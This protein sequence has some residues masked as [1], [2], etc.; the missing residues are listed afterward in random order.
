MSSFN[1][2]EKASKFKR[3]DGSFFLQDRLSNKDIPKRLLDIVAS[4]LGLLLL[5]P[6]FGLIAIA[7]KRDSPGPVFYRGLRMGRN[8]QPFNMLKFRTMYETSESY[9]GTPV[10]PEGDPRVTPSGKW[11]RA[12]KLNE[13]PQLWNILK[14][15]MS[16]VGPR[17]ENVQI[18]E[19]W[20]EKVQQEILSVR[21]GITSPAS[22]AY[23]NEEQLLKGSSFMDDY[24]KQILPD[25][26]RLDQLYVQ[27]RS[28]LSDLDVIFITLLVLLPNLRKQQINERWLYSGPIYLFY[29]RV[30]GWF[31]VDVLVTFFTVGLSGIVW[32]ISTVINL[33]APTFMLMALVIAVLLSIINTALGLHRISW[34]HASLTYVIDIGFSVGLT[35][36]IFWIVTRVWFTEPWI[37][38]SLI[39]LIGVMT[40]IG[41]VVVRYRERL[42]TGISHRWLL[43]RGGKASFAERILVVGAGE[44]G[45]LTIWLLQRSAFSNLFGVVGVVDDDARKQDL[46]IRGLKVLGTTQNIPE[47]VEKYKIGII[48]YA[49][50]NIKPTENEKILQACRSTSARTII[51]PDLVKVLENSF[52]KMEVQE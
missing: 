13:L 4:V 2:Q 40:F 44:L 5:L 38:F 27:N 16:L 33:G 11:L 47:I 18:A 34:S 6:I 29:N 20:P 45:E 8:K 26:L 37:P 50:A 51:I 35:M 12:T 10:T 32:R 39:W 14:G 7:I 49:I 1:K 30:F 52:T 23:R 28:F 3:S 24:L 9:N 48:I 41:L 43:M 36:L 31:L 15:E 21:P 17:P 42:L 19:G 22:V 46:N 25:K